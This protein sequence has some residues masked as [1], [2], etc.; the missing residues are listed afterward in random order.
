MQLQKKSMN[1]FVMLLFL[2]CYIFLQRYNKKLRMRA[3]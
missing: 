1:N 3:E 2:L